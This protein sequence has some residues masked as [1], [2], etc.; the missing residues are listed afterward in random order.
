M[1]RAIILILCIFAVITTQNTIKLMNDEPFLSVALYGKAILKCC[2]KSEAMSLNRTWVR[3]FFAGNKSVG[4]ESVNDANPVENREGDK[5]C[6]TLTLSSVKKK[7]SGLYQCLV[8][9]SLHT[10]GTYLQVYRPLQK[11]INLSESTKNKI[12]T[13]EG[14]LL[15]LCVLLPSVTL[16]FKSKRVNEL[17][18]K[19]MKKEEE[20]IYQGLNLDDCCTTYDQIERSQANGPYQDVCNII[21]EEEDIQLEK[22]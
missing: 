12:L 11:T 4:P 1:E 20:N 17:E 10:H 5:E 19:K 3:S 8:N 9:G 6:S 22:P 14:V 18:K 15:L 16:L 13:A 7:D 21:E 2:Y